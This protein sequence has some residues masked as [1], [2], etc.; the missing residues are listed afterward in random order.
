MNYELIRIKQYWI[1][2]WQDGKK[3]GHLSRGGSY[4]WFIMI[5]ND[6]KMLLTSYQNLALAKQ[7]LEVYMRRRQKRKRKR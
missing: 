6:T 1:E 7:A 4:Q 2:V 5:D 3:I